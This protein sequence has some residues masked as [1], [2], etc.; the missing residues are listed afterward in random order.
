[1]AWYGIT[2]SAALGVTLAADETGLSGII[3]PSWAAAIDTSGLICPRA[4]SI[5]RRTT[6][7]KI[8]LRSPACIAMRSPATSPMYSSSHLLSTCSI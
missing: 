7:L 8:V 4:L 1:M 5:P 6:G 3:A 2:S